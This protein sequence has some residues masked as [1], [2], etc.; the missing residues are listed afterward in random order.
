MTPPAV[1]VATYRLQ[2]SAQFGFDD[3]AALVPYLKA[4]GISH[5]YA[6]PFLQA[7]AG[8][9]HGYDIVDHNTLNTEFG[10]EAGFDRLSLALA[11]A[12]M[13][14]ILDFVPN[15]MGVGHADNAWWL[16]VL[17]WGPRSR[18][19]EF[20]D[21]DWS[22][23]PYRPGG[24]LLLPILG[25]PYGTALER[26]D[27]ELRYD[28]AEG[29]FSAWYFDHRLPIR[30]NRYSEIIRVLVSAAGAADEPAGRALIAFAE[31]Y[32]DPGAPDRSEAS[33]FKAEL[34]AIAGG[35]DVIARGLHAYRPDGSDPSRA[36]LLHRLLERQH[37][38]LAHWRVAVSEINYRRFF[39]IN[40]LAGIRIESP[41]TFGAVHRLVARL[42][43]EKR[44]HGLRIDHIDGLSDPVQYCRRLQPV[45]RG[46]LGIAPGAPHE[47]F[48]VVVEKILSDG[49]K[50]PRFPGV[51]GSTGYDVLNVITRVLL[52]DGGLP[53]LDRLWRAVSPRN[54]DFAEVLA[55]AKTRILEAILSS[56]FTVLA[57]LLARIAAGHWPSRDYTGDRLHAALQ[58]FVLHFP[59][60]RTYIGAGGVSTEDRATIGRAIA[61]A[62][63][64]WFGGDADIFDFL[65]DA[66]TRDLVA[67]G[68]P[69]YSKPR[70]RRFSGKVQQF[71]GPVMAKAM[72]DTAFYRYH[73]LLALNEVGG[74]PGLSGLTVADFHR[75]MAE[76][77]VRFPHALAATA[78]HD[79]KRGED[80]RTRILALAELADDWTA[81]IARWREMNARLAEPWR[82]PS[83]RA[84]SVE[85]EYMLY[86]ALI[87]AWPAQPPPLI[88]PGKT[89]V[90]RM[91]AYAVKA[92]REGKEETS[93]INADQAYESALTRF[94][95]RLL[96]A[97]ESA[98]F[99]QDFSAFAQRASLIGALSSLSQLVLKATLPGVP[100][101]YQGTELWDLALV[102]PDNRRP[103]DFAARRG[104]LEQLGAGADWATLAAQWTDGRIKLAL[105][106]RL[107]AL[108]HELPE[109]FM[110]GGY[111]PIEVSGRDRDRVIA[112]ARWTKREAMIVAVG[113]HFAR[114]SDGGRRWPRR[115]DW[116]AAL[117]LD[118]FVNLRDALRP[119]SPAGGMARDLFA[120]LP[121]AMFRA[122]RRRLPFLRLPHRQL[123]TAG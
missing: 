95:A 59:V 24:G 87:G 56:E 43:A 100:D 69:G 15:H 61:A 53:A 37:Y 27:I 79:T 106:H 36:V 31:R 104:A 32:S 18:Y 76:R 9:T 7:R 114:M 44:L 82:E 60:Y 2:L 10:G 42:I 90:E 123:S 70:V 6:S 62:R 35:A 4:L 65:Q 8:S 11:D 117:A 13:G 120:V 99:L 109:L 91:Q 40:D 63:A 75:R 78:T 33:Q 113:R 68:R 46:A 88:A 71:T 51:A 94:V 122:N 21:I 47:P 92:A 102:D 38:R 66:L 5:L 57:R 112:F 23:L 14:L 86:Q 98:A 39:D 3:A 52:D 64:R 55:Q 89:F 85:H 30:P 45:I 17:E 28:A 110:D 48:Y 84:P 80:A 12:G 58:Q 20:F 29:S 105:T 101:F 121:V 41:R 96:D 107:L 118:R 16:D 54:A 34:A 49:E 81:A 111:E 97:G 26:G 19:A 74:D 103:V 108:R 119:E 73:R 22:T 50:M 67:P 116:D 1:P 93:W 25:T 72:E 77:A 115:E 83:L